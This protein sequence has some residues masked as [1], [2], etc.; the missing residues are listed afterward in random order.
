MAKKKRKKNKYRYTK[1]E[2]FNI[3]CKNCCACG[4]KDTEDS[5]CYNFYGINNKRFI[6]SVYP[7]LRKSMWS[8]K[9]HIQISLF[10]SMFCE[11][12]SKFTVTPEDTN[13]CNY[14]EECFNLF[15]EQMDPVYTK[16]LRLDKFTSDFINKKTL[17]HGNKKNK[18]KEKYVVQPYIT[19][20]YSRDEDWEREV[21]SVNGKNNNKEQDTS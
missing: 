4:I 6:T 8:E 3:L 21:R 19:F 17:V 16:S 12:C 9:E 15:Q 10:Y 1:G 20:F 2:F 11:S 14:I 5:F 7:R 18:K 13:N